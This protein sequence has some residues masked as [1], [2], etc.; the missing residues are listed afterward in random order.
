MVR[1]KSTSGDH[2]NGE[3]YHSGLPALSN[4]DALVRARPVLPAPSCSA[5]NCGGGSAL[6]QPLAALGF[7]GSVMVGALSQLVPVLSG[8]SWPPWWRDRTWPLWL[9]TIG[10]LA[11]VGHFLWPGPPTAGQLLGYGAL[12]ALFASLGTLAM[13]MLWLLLRLP[14]LSDSLRDLR[15]VAAG[16]VA[17]LCSTL[18]VLGNR[19]EPFAALQTVEHHTWVTLHVA[20][21]LLQHRMFRRLAGST[22]AFFPTYSWHANLLGRLFRGYLRHV[23]E[24]HSVPHLASSAANA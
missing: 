11:L 18:I 16:A 9:Y 5:P 23:G 20:T 10:V 12:V 6:A 17:T 19:L 4:A 21:G 22:G 3:P 14:I 8:Q 1:W 15:W 7:M 24:N 2:E 13:A